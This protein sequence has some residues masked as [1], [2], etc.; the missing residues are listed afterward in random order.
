LKK[1]EPWF[2]EGCAGLLHQKKH[3]RLQWSQNPREI[4][5]GKSEQYQDVKPA[6]I[7]GKKK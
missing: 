4:N 6:S 5:G 2:D 3:A 7:S 1:H